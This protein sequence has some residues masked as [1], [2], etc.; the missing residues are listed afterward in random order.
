MDVIPPSELAEVA[1]SGD[2]TVLDLRSE[3][4]FEKNHISGKNI[5]TVNVYF[6]S[7]R[8]KG[9]SAIIDQI[10]T[11]K[12]V[13]VCWAGNCSTAIARMLEDEGF[14][15]MSLEGGMQNWG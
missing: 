6:H 11:D 7:L 12:V 1:E 5:E 2:L 14:E 10:D 4:E 3:E 9:R 8:E 15:A 13:V